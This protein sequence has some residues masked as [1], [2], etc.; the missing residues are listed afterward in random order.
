MN[1]SSEANDDQAGLEVLPK[2]RVALI[3]CGNMVEEAVKTRD[4]LIAEAGIT[5]LFINARFIKP[6]DETLL[7]DITGKFDIIAFA[8]ETCEAGSYGERAVAV[9]Q[10]ELS[11]LLNGEKYEL[12]SSQTDIRIPKIINFCIKVESVP[13]GSVDELREMLGISA[14]CM[15][16][17]ITSM[18]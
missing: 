15:Y 10:D 5:P 17:K 3:A 9:I 6:I 18:L 13:Q 14:D 7:R 8:E 16:E 1:N 12:G 2:K 11:K 4:R